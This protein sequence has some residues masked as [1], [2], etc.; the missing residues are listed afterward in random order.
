[1]RHRL[2]QLSI[3]IAFAATAG[4]VAWT[5]F[6]TAARWECRVGGELETLRAADASARNLYLR[7]SLFLAEAPRSAWIQVIGRGKLEL[8]VNGNSLGREKSDVSPVAIIADLTPYLLPGKNVVAV[9]CRQE[10]EGERPEVSVQ[11]AYYASGQKFSL[12]DPAQWRHN[13]TFDRRHDYWFGVDYDDRPWPLA[14]RS[15]TRMWATLPAPARAFSE[16][17]RGEWL[18]PSVVAVNQ[19]EVGLDFQVPEAID[20]A[21]LRLRSNASTRLALNGVVLE[22]TDRSLGTVNQ[23]VAR[24]QW[25]YDLSPFVVRG[26]NALRMQLDSAA[27]T[28][29][30]AA[31]L[32]CVG[33]SGKS[34]WFASS[35]AWKWW[36]PDIANWLAPTIPARAR[37]CEGSKGP[38]FEL[39]GRKVDYRP[40]AR[41]TET[42]KAGR[43]TGDQHQPRDA[44]DKGRFA[45]SADPRR[46]APPARAVAE[47]ELPL[48]YYARQIGSELLLMAVLAVVGGGL[49]AMVQRVMIPRAEPSGRRGVAPA[50]L[51]LLPTTGLFAAAI[52]ATLDPR[53]PLQSV[54][55][56]L[57]FVVGMTLLPVQ[58]ALL[59]L[60]G[61]GRCDVA[62]PLAR[63]TSR[64]WALAAAVLLVLAVGASL[65]LSYLTYRPMS[66]DEVTAYRSALGFWKYGF[67]ALE[68]H[69]DMP[70]VYAATSELVHLVNVLASVFFDYDR[71]VVRAGPF[72]CG[73][74]T[75]WLVY[76][77]TSRLFH[78][79]A[80]VIAA[81]IY[82]LSPIAINM[83]TWG[84]Y[85]SQLQMFTLLTAY[86]FYRAIEPRDGI[87]RKALWLTVASFIGMFLSW[88]G[89]AL[90]ALP[91][92]GLA[93]FQ[94]RTR[95][96]ALFR[97]TDVWLGLLL[98]G[99]V[100]LAQF[101]HRTFVQVARPFY[102]TGASDV[103]LTPMWRYPEFDLWY[104][105]WAATWSRDTLLPF[106]AL[107]SGLL[108]VVRHPYAKPARAMFVILLGTGLLEGLLLPIKAMRYGYH[109]LPLWL[110]LSGAGIWALA[111][112]LA[113][114]RALWARPGQRRYARAVSA[115]SVAG[116]LLLASGW[117]VD[118]AEL[119]RWRAPGT[120]LGAF[121]FPGQMY[122]AQY[123]KQH[124]QPGD[125]IITNTPHLI[126]HYSGH[127]SDYWLQSQ[128]Y[129]Q[130]TLDDVQTVPRHK[131]QG[132]RMIRNLAELKDVFSRGQ[133][134]W[135]VG[136][137][138]FNDESNTGEVC[139]FL[140][141]NMD[142]VFEDYHAVVML[143]DGNHRPQLTQ[144]ENELLLKRSG[145]MLLP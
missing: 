125:V 34:Y 72:C 18:S 57:L 89:S 81:T 113:S 112:E 124:W 119:D 59:L 29:Q 122:T 85:C 135:F 25:I 84:R 11:G 77:C 123:L 118:L 58:W 93:L 19:M 65:R 24:K 16:P 30:L 142:V 64:R 83:A 54:Y 79:G 101:S 35:P 5:T 53:V 12:S 17:A 39:L 33:R 60:A 136:E 67:P 56:P 87:N 109:L 91:M 104:F 22:H 82:A 120:R 23:S 95:L 52:L 63:S 45:K 10:M 94:Q 110:M 62:T 4:H 88:E 98:V 129:L 144:D 86:F 133:R 68:I 78:P 96:A 80:G 28:P 41:S 73:V 76:W 74:I 8:Y 130:A 49:C 141:G 90:I 51:A 38:L 43:S 61:R 46:L 108:L 42:A 139:A 40:A 50:Y 126:D 69:K 140:R 105:V 92:M 111:S 1:M 132:T 44:E 47:I 106:L 143:R 2:I 70:V 3:V 114:D 66:S 20:Y 100:V 102:G 121:I 9:V 31:D 99:A 21:W 48:R 26:H 131:Y 37:A 55:Q 107:L 36:S 7:R 116:F 71:L 27:E 6:G 137:P 103:Q 115:L 145:A 127:P 32:E 117:T 97:R 128:L 134:V 75:I 14:E 138:I 13:T 15:Q